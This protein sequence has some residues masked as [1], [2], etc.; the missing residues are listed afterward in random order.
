MDGYDSKEV[1]V[2]EALTRYVFLM[3]FPVGDRTFYIGLQVK[4]E[5]LTN[6]SL[7]VTRRK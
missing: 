2:K 7:W 1:A 6:L 3:D 4:R 5:M